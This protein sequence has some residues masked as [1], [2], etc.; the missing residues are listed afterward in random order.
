MPASTRL[1]IGLGEAGVSGREAES[2]TLALIGAVPAPGGVSRSDTRSPTCSATDCAMRCACSGRGSVAV[3][4]RIT[5]SG[6]TVDETFSD[7]CDG[8][9]SSPRSSITPWA[10]SR[11]RTR[12]AYEPIR[13][14]EKRLPW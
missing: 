9:M 7:S 13:C 5:V 14:A 3:I 12:S 8:V 6:T 1:R 11:L 4:W 10:T 2:T